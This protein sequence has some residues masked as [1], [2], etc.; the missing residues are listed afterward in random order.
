VQIL[1]DENIPRP[2]V[3]KLRTL[4]H[5]ELDIRGAQEKA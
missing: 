1:V 4:G 2:I 5:G 3:V